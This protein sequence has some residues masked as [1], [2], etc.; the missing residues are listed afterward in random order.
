MNQTFVDITIFIL[1]TLL[2]VEYDNPISRKDYLTFIEYFEKRLSV[3]INETFESVE[4]NA[5]YERKKWGRIKYVNK[6][7]WKFTHIIHTLEKYNIITS[8]GYLVNEHSKRYS[9][10]EAFLNA[11]TYTNI[12]FIKEEINDK[13]YENLKST[14][15]YDET[16]PQY[17]LIKS[18]RFALDTN[19]CIEFIIKSYDTEF[20]SKNSVLTN[21]KRILDINNKEIFTVRINNGRVYT[22]FS[23]LKR[24][25]RKYCTIDGVALE[26][27]DLKS[28]QPY[29]LIHYLKNKYPDSI[30]IKRLYDI[31]VNDDIY[32]WIIKKCDE[33]LSY[34]IKS[35]D[36]CKV[37]VF[38]Y[39]FKKT[40]KG[41]D[42][43]QK[44]F[45]KIFPDVYEIISKERKIFMKQNTTLADYLQSLEAEI[46]IPVCEKYVSRGCLS[47]HDSL[48]FVPGLRGEIEEDLKKSF[49]EKGYK[50]FKLR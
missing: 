9:Y 11:I 36:D 43:V 38:S 34:H 18:D 41:N 3:N 29:L 31:V 30:G 21:L 46:F 25:L 48:Y 27:L 10:T 32:D 20:K 22:S 4:L 13:L 6:T 37:I 24:E 40:N 28:A 5:N 1:D 44:L 26:S 19:K 35:R 39:I 2:K 23:S 12:Q 49:L 15:Y 45:K 8:T 14:K 50:E 42:K 7:V 33:E 17:Q 16:N 47:V